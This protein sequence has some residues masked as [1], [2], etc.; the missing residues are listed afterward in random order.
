[1]ARTVGIIHVLDDFGGKRSL[2][3]TSPLRLFKLDTALS[4]RP[5]ATCQ[6]A[7]AGGSSVESGDRRIRLDHGVLELGREY[8]VSAPGGLS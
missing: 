8:L 6:T 3:L 7:K 4:L 2:K 5:F 1:M